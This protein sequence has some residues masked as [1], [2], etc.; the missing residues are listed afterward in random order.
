MGLLSVIKS[1][2]HPMVGIFIGAWHNLA[3]EEIVVWFFRK[4]CHC[5]SLRNHKNLVNV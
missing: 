2:N 3:I 5:H 4:L 1:T